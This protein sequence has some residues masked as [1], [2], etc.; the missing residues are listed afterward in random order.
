MPRIQQLPPTVVNKIAAGEVIERPASV[1]KELLENAVDAGGTPH[2]RR[3]R[4]GRHRPDPRRRRRLRHRR[5][6]P[7]AGLR[8]PRHQ[9]AR[10]TPTTCSASARSASAARRWPPSA[11]SPRSRC[12]RGRRTSRAAP[13]SPATAA[14]CPPVRPWNGSPGTRIEVRHL[15]YNTPVRTQVPRDASAPRWATSARRSPGWPWPTRRCTCVLRHNGKLVYEVPGVGRAARPHRPVLRRARSRDALYAV[16]AEHGPVHAARLRRRPGLRPRQRQDAVP[17]RQR[18]LGARP[19]PRPRGAGGVPRPADDRPLRGRLPVPG[20][21]AGPG[22]RERPPDQGRG[23]LPRRAGA[24]PPGLGSGARPAAARRT[25]SPRL[26]VPRERSAAGRGGAAGASAAVARRRP[27]GSRGPRDGR[28]PTPAPPTPPAAA[29]RRPT[30]AAPAGRR[31]RSTARRRASRR[32]PDRPTTPAAVADRRSRCTTP[33]SS[34]RRPTGMLVIDQHALHERIL[35]EQLQRARPRRAAGSRS[36]CSSPSRSTCPPSR[37]RRVLE[38]RDALAE[39]GL[40][41]EDFGGGTV[42]LTQLPGPAGP[43]RRR[44][45]SSAPSSITWSRKDRPP[46]PRA[47]CSTTCWR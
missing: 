47:C 14:S 34:S 26:Q 40:E 1:V 17:V 46:T 33:T 7:A 21:A 31:R 5:R 23:A 29:W 43:A 2:R 11:A 38:Q 36:G 16:E 15:F 4:A 12:S 37:R 24:V 32:P 18:P 10:A 28:P 22:G 6:R 35:F 3:R 44:A 9:Q 27:A 30:P 8:Q 19:Q 13:R 20:A 39:L 41:V 25:W 45:R 42:L